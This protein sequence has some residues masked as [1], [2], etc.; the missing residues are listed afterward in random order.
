MSTPVVL[1]IFSLFLSVAFWLLGVLHS[2][3]APAGSWGRKRNLETDGARLI[4]IVAFFTLYFS[5][6]TLL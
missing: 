2:L 1:G 4:L 3:D 5:L 6:V